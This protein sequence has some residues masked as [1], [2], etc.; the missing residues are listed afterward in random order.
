MRNLRDYMKINE[1]SKGN[2]DKDLMD[3][4]RDLSSLGM[5]KDR[6]FIKTKI[7]I[8]GLRFN[9]KLKFPSLDSTAG[10]IKESE[11]FRILENGD[12]KIE[13]KEDPKNLEKLI[14]SSIIMFFSNYHYLKLEEGYKDL[15]YEYLAFVFKFKGVSEIELFIDLIRVMHFQ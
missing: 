13:I 3:L 1:N 12:Y 11:I 14:H 9:C 7:I 4:Y 2:I 15:L 8:N 6:V 10:E 5:A